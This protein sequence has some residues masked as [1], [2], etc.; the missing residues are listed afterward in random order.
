MRG[1]RSLIWPSIFQI[2]SIRYKP[3]MAVNTFNHR[4]PFHYSN[5][6]IKRFQ[7]P[8]LLN[9][10]HLMS[11]E[12]PSSH[13]I[14]EFWDLIPHIL[15]HATFRERVA[16]S[17]CDRSLREDLLNSTRSRIHAQLTDH[18]G[19]SIDSFWHLWRTTHSGLIGS[20][21]LWSLLNAPSWT[22]QEINI[23]TTPT[24]SSAWL[25]WSSTEGFSAATRPVENSEVD[26]IYSIWCFQR[27]Q[28]RFCCENALICSIIHRDRT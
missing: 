3:K 27:P 21:A 5:P 2:K 1:L 10:P 16:L 7:C 11:A 26:H 6:L 18:L 15:S 14:R 8:I 25:D 20:Y 22:P 13:T 12:G 28:V 24:N 4:S 17:H 9:A 19:T 23:V